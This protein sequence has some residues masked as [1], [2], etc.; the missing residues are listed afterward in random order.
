MNKMRHADTS[1]GNMKMINCNRHREILR[2]NT[3]FAGQEII[4]F[5]LA[6]KFVGKD[7]YSN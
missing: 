2:E 5:L 4:I 7:L 3:I 6:V 1:K